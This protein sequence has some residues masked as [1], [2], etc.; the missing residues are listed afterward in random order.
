MFTMFL[1]C[2]IGVYGA[3]HDTRAL[4]TMHMTYIG[5]TCA[6]RVTRRT[7]CV[8]CCTYHVGSEMSGDFHD[9]FCVFSAHR[10]VFGDLSDL[11]WN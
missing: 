10:F 1:V 11:I 9:L 6:A 3:M 5:I 2:A 8:L 7:M 4:R